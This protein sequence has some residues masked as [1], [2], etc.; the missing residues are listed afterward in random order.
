MIIV[1]DVTLLHWDA[2]VQWHKTP[3]ENSWTGFSQV[4]GEQHAFNFR[5]WHEEDIA[6][7]PQATDTEI[8]AVKRSID[9]LNQQRNDWIEKLDD[10]ITSELERYRVRPL[11]QARSYTETPGS[12]IDRLSIM[13]LRIFHLQEQLDRQ[14]VSQDHHEV[15]QGKLDVCLVQRRELA[16]ALQNLLDDI[17]D[18][19]A[20]HRVYR[21]N[22]MYNDR[23][24]NPQI[25]NAESQVA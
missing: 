8:A 22:K 4:V 14:D 21:Q 11:N 20:R 18:G 7:N 12:A 15:V 24:F 25:Y 1:N 13:A 6:R 5:L 3:I 16:S 23:R 9:K 2:V 19:R 17:F 10:F